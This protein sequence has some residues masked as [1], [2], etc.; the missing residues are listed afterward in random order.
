[1][2]ILMFLLIMALLGC[3]C[4]RAGVGVLA[5]INPLHYL[6]HPHQHHPGRTTVCKKM[7]E[8]FKNCEEMREGVRRCEKMREMQENVRR[9]ARNARKKARKFVR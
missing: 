8:I 4:A 6:H 9:F 1:M 5:S 3:C 7:R 2:L